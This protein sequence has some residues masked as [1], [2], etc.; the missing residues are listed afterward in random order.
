[1]KKSVWIVL[2]FFSVACFSQA[3]SNRQKP[4]L[5]LRNLD[6]DSIAVKLKALDS[7]VKTETANRE[8]ESMQRDLNEFMQQQEERT[9]KQKRNAIFR[10]GFGLMM[11]AVLVIGLRRRKKIA[12]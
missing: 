1:M 9:R 12:K 5:R 2:L 3:D 10:I 8:F 6:R 7:V 4:S 11:L